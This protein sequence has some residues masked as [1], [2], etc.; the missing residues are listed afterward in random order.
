MRVRAARWLGA[1]LV[2][3]LSA[4]GPGAPTEQAGSAGPPSLGSNPPSSPATVPA[5]S[6][7]SGTGG[8]PGPSGTQAL[9]ASPVVSAAP[10]AI[11]ASLLSLLPRTVGGR[12][13]VETPDAERST[14]ADPSVARA[15][16]RLALGYVA[17]ADAADWAI[18]S[19]VRLRPGTWSDA[20]YRDWRDSYDAAVCAARDGVAGNASATIGGRLVD[21]ATCGPLRT[22]HVH[23]AGEDVI[24]SVASVGAGGYG[25]QLMAGLRP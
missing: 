16:Q 23:L 11:D 3:S 15:A 19:V 10:A 21:I 14:S 7:S 20:F 22:Y 8:S 1:A 25:E 12:P 17:S 9:S 13:I 18:A 24:V 4:C 5:A 6:A 2:V